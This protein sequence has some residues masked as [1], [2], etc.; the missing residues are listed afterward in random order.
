[1]AQELRND[2]D[3]KFSQVNGVGPAQQIQTEERFKSIETEIVLMKGTAASASTAA[4]VRSPPGYSTSS[5]YAPPVRAASPS[6]AR[7]STVINMKAAY[8]EAGRGYGQEDCDDEGCDGDG[9]ARG[10]MIG[11]RERT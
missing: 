11:P 2:Y 1:M 6:Y 5:L 3:G 4:P 9:P 10:R 7:T 8:A